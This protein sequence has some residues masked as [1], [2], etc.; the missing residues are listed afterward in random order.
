MADRQAE[1]RRDVGSVRSDRRD[2]VHSF[3]SS[4]QGRRL[5]H[6]ALPA[7]VTAPA[8]PLPRVPPSLT[9]C[10]HPPT[11]T[12]RVLSQHALERVAQRQREYR[13]S[14]HSRQAP[15]T[16][17]SRLVAALHR[18]RAGQRRSCERDA[19]DAGSPKA[20]PPPLLFSTRSALAIAAADE[21]EALSVAAGL[22]RR[23]A[24]SDPQEP[25]G[26]HGFGSEGAPC[27]LG[28]A[29]AIRARHR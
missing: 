2:V 20:L 25:G 17:R 21:A 19:R 8:P 16:R 26:R 9:P 7:S 3:H 1:H 4:R 18:Q 6:S 15:A 10:D 23:A 29:A 27:A 22:A 12:P 5:L 28:A 14:K 13:A 11:R 24:A